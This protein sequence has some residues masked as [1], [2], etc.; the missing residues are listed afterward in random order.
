VN[1]NDPLPSVHPLTREAAVESL[2][3]TA[4]ILCRDEHSGVR[5][6]GVALKRWLRGEF[7]TIEHALG[8]A[9]P[10]GSHATP[11]AIAASLIGDE[12]AQDDIRH[13]LGHRRS[14]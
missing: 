13:S 9:A 7:P 1:L 12:E 2:L 8:I 10:R 14:A 4:D 11:R 6:V 5:R 3:K